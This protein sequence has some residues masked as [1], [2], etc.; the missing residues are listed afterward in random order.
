MF[1]APRSDQRPR[2]D[3]DAAAREASLWA[4]KLELDFIRVRTAAESAVAVE[5]FDTI[6]STAPPV[7]VIDAS[8]VVAMAS[9]G[10]QI[11]VATRHGRPVGAAMGFFGAP[12]ESYH[13]HVVGV[14]RD[15]TLRGVGFA[16]KLYQRAWCLANDMPTMTWTFDP[17]VSRN[18][19]FNL[20]KLGA[21]AVTFHADHY[22]PMND[23]VNAGQGSDRLLMRWQLDRAVGRE[24]IPAD[25]DQG[26]GSPIG[27]IRIPVPRD[28][29]AIRAADPATA[30]DWRMR[31]RAA[32]LS[33]SGDGWRVE[34]FTPDGEY[35][36][37]RRKFS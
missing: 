1:A 24:P 6:W 22:G 20:N 19:H 17:L 14:L 36:L 9:N 30:V 33:A 27:E 16:L 29:E 35:V 3:A 5:L 12:G 23:G 4:Q 31:S 15:P 13:S 18:A 10:N 7:S 32:F 11:V 2:V 8:T 25:G 26:E 37:R 21:D 34:E 28:I